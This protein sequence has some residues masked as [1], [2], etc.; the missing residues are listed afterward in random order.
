MIYFL[1][2]EDVGRCKIGFSENPK[3]RIRDL[4]NSSPVRLRSLGEMVGD[5]DTEQKLH[6]DFIFLHIKNE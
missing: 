1:L 2:A 4:S 5:H 3:K 6:D